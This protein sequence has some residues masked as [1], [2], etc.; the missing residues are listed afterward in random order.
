M[1]IQTDSNDDLQAVDAAVT[2]AGT[3]P[4]EARFGSEFSLAD[5]QADIRRQMCEVYLAPV[6]RHHLEANTIS[7]NEWVDETVTIQDGP[8]ITMSAGDTS[9]PLV[10]F[11]HGW[12]DN[13]AIW[14]NQFMFLSRDYHCVAVQLPN[15]LDAMPTEDLYVDEVVDRVGEVLNGRQAYLVAHDWGANFGYMVAYKFPELILKYASL[16]IGND[17]QMWLD[18]QDPGITSP[19]ALFIRFYQTRLAAAYTDPGLLNDATVSTFALTGGSPGGHATA[20]MGMYYARVWNRTEFQRRLAPDVPEDE[21]E[22]LWTPLGGTGIPQPGMLYIQGSTLATTPLFLDAVR[23]DG[24]R[25][26]EIMDGGHWVP[27]GAAASVTAELEAWLEHPPGEHI[28]EEHYPVVFSLQEA[29]QQLK[30]QMCAEYWVQDAHPLNT[31]CRSE[32]QEKITIEKSGP[33][34]TARAGDPANQMIVFI[35]G[36]PD[37]AALWVNQL[38]RFSQNYYCIAVQLPN[39]LDVLPTE[40]LYVDE[41]VDRIG[42]VIGDRKTLLVGHDWGANLGYMVAYKF[43]DA[44]LKYAALDI[45]NDLQMW[46]DVAPETRSLAPMNVFIAYYQTQLAAAYRNCF[47]GRAIVEVFARTGGSPGGHG[48]C[49]M[50]MLYHHAWNRVEFQQRMAPDVAVEDWQSLWTPLGGTGIP[51]SGM[52]YIQGSTLATTDKFLDAVRADGGTVLQLLNGEAGHWLPV[53]GT[54][55][56]NQALERWFA[57]SGSDIYESVPYDI[58]SFT[59]CSPLVV[60]DVYAHGFRLT[61]TRRDQG[62][63]VFH[64]RC[65]GD[66]SEE[67]N[68]NKIS[69]QQNH[70]SGQAWCFVENDCWE[71]T[72]LLWACSALSNQNPLNCAQT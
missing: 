63:L 48:T 23:A 40:E 28:E 10:V 69:C 72:Q 39:Y 37:S 22:G 24:G 12:P 44:V 4:Y 42:R 17:I 60:R 46:I 18:A 70:C 32:V 3:Q 1:R 20:R 2:T 43:P 13:A 38:L 21:W 62:G 68:V 61:E 55:H 64:V 19:M 14:V 30:A 33:L 36:W 49:R 25:V 31:D 47:T 11:I 27:V 53:Q 52:L 67:P 41:Y 56:V 54:A 66:D 7:C 34:V 8:M 51:Q 29:E 9:K 50:G 35:H 57:G 71:S 59:A 45:A 6:A 5:V 26:V 16:D 58:P 65:A 15:Y